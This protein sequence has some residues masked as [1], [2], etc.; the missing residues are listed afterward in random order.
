[1]NLLDPFLQSAERHGDRTAI[2]AGNGDKTSFVDLIA[3]SSALAAAWQRAGIGKGDRV[4]IAMPLGP[5]LYAGLA[6]LWRI[7]A[8]AVLPEPALG[9]KGLRHAARATSPKAY[10]SDGWYRLLKHLVPELWPIRLSLTPAD[11]TMAGDP[12]EGLTPDHP[13]LISFTSGSTG[14]PK[15]IQRSHGFLAAQSAI[16]AEL[17]APRR[18]DETD[19][20]AFPV[21]VVANLG[22][23]VTSVLPRWNL[24][25]H[26]RAEPD[27]VARQIAEERVTRALLPPSVCEALTHSAASL[28]LDTIF[29]GGGPVFPDLLERLAAT[30]P[31]TDI[32]AVYGST[33]AEP[34]A[35]LHHRDIEPAD[36]QAMKSGA[37]LLA[38]HPVDAIRVAIREDEIIVT[39]DHVN[40]GYLDPADDGSTKLWR[41]GEI[42]HRTGDAGRFD[43][44]GRL[45]LGGRLDG[46]AGGILPFGVEAASRFWPGIRRSAL[47]ES[48]GRAILAVEGDLDQLPAWT[49]A[50]ALI[51]DVHVIAISEIPLDKRHRSKVDYVTLRAKLKGMAQ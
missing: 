34:I 2:V 26:D 7:G 51:G 47:V 31:G 30:M 25:R 1:M 18:A 40:K 22:M 50:A 8:V 29:T 41:E 37:G 21:F 48:D 43:G 46:R 42:W 15:A 14:K 12:L 28:R 9:L 39:G 45:W 11:G 10:L 27:L 3:V 19:L 17:L 35:H 5:S 24:R 32:V 23:G 44:A 6:A 13:A 33:E 20:V 16:L 36:W 38:G 4:L 49:R